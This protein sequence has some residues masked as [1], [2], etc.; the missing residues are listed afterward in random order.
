MFGASSM[1]SKPML[2][3]DDVFFSPVGIPIVI[4]RKSMNVMDTVLEHLLRCYADSRTQSCESAS[5]WSISRLF[6]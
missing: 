4:G 6:I 3:V 1:A 2:T 5:I